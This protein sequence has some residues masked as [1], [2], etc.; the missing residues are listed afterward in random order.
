[1]NRFRRIAALFFSTV[2]LCCFPGAAALARNSVD[3]DRDCELTVTFRN[4]AADGTEER[5]SGAEFR[6]YRIA[7]IDR[8]SDYH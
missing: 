5:I 7:D 1:M 2:I 3:V 8:V 6:I 4:T